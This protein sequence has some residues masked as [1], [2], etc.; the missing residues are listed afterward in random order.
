MVL[1]RAGSPPGPAARDRVELADEHMS[2]GHATVRAPQPAD[3]ERGAFTI[4][5]R[6]D[7]GP[8]ANGTFVNSHKLTPK[9]ALRLG[10]GDVIRLG[11]TEL[12]FKSLWLPPARPASRCRAAG[13]AR[14]RPRR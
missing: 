9:E 4:T 8:S 3:G 11:T 7:P 14:C 6:Q 13:P 10:D 12:V 2:I 1:S 5:D